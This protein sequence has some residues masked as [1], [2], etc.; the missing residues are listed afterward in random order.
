MSLGNCETELLVKLNFSNHNWPADLS[1][2]QQNMYSEN[3]LHLI[4]SRPQR[5]KNNRTQIF[6]DTYLATSA[7]H[8]SDYTPGFYF[9]KT[10]ILHQ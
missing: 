9:R 5:M 6:T 8:K 7:N 1:L 10:S 4:E 2:K 3:T